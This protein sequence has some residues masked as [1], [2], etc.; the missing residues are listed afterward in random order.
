MTK[1]SVIFIYLFR[2]LY[3]KNI[4]IVNDIKLSDKKEYVS[5]NIDN[6]EGNLDLFKREL[7][8]YLLK[9]KTIIL[10]ISNASTAKNIINYM[11]IDDLVLTNINEIIKNKINLINYSIGNGYI[12]NDYVV[13]SNN[14]I[15]K[16]N[17]KNNYN[18]SLNHF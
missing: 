4:N 5:Y 13:I 15:F 18:L 12:F 1:I 11:E 3:E 9:K 8:K 10:C 6:Y 7:N 17:K 2:W 14:D 16:I